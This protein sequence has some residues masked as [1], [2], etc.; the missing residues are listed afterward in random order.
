[1]E[2][3][4]HNS[5]FRQVRGSSG[6]GREGVFSS[7]GGLNWLSCAKVLANAGIYNCAQFT[8]E[9][10]LLNGHT[11]VSQLFVSHFRT[12]ELIGSALMCTCYERE[13]PVT[14]YLRPPLAPL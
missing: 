9:I 12:I 1:M 6:G 3:R 8:P 13:T 5:Q 4:C 14:H 11:I 10:A 2:Y 7:F